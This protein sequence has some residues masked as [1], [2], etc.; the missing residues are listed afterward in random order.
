MAQR[1]CTVFF[2]RHDATG[3]RSTSSTGP[4]LHDEVRVNGHAADPVEYVLPADV[5][6]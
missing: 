3:T 2:T 4:R 6:D 1:S 5:S